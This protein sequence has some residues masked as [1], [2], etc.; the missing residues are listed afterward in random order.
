MERG[1]PTISAVNNREQ[2]GDFNEVAAKDIE[3]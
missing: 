1:R 2:A 3:I